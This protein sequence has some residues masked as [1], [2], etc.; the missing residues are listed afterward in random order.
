MSEV[1]CTKFRQSSIGAGVYAKLN[2]GIF[3]KLQTTGTGYSLLYFVNGEGVRIDIPTCFAL[4]DITNEE[5]Y[6]S[7]VVSTILPGE[8]LFVLLWE[9]NYEMQY[10][11]RTTRLVQDS[12]WAVSGELAWTDN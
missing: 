7:P 6:G 2:D 11:G 1:P 4:Y 9:R 5:D 8:H 12:R 10:A 3:A